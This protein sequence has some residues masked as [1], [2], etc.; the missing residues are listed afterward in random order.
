VSFGEAIHL[1]NELKH[2][3]GSHL[4]ADLN[5]WDFVAT[6]GELMNAIHL[7]AFLNAN[8]D[9]KKQRTPFVVPKP[10]DTKAPRVTAE[11]RAALEQQL[12]RRSAF[13]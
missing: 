9:E 8:R 2:E 1:V 13:A 12:E 10:M 7:E 5:G 6:Y 11:E 4:S 3:F